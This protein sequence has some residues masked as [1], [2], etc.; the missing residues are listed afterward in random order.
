MLLCHTEL[1][2]KHPWEF[3]IIS[4]DLRQEMCLLA[5][6][7]CVAPEF[8]SCTSTPTVSPQ[9]EASD[10]APNSISLAMDLILIVYCPCVFKFISYMVS[11]ICSVISHAKHRGLPNFVGSLLF[12]VGSATW[13]RL[14]A[15]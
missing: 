11:W 10:S 4:Q 3:V 14:V 15:G 8:I 12:V 1:W 5:A 13:P 9:F 7:G 2:D 6:S